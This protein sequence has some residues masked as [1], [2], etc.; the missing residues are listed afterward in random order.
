MP[1]GGCAWRHPLVCCADLHSTIADVKQRLYTFNGSNMGMVELHLKD[2]SGALL[3]RMLD[4]D[5]M[6]GYYGVQSGMTI[7]VVDNDPFS[8]SRDGGCVN[9]G[10]WPQRS[11]FEFGHEPPASASAGG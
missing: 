9:T 1:G 11:P 10:S 5:R 4:D 8:L 7:H 3:A 6:L 2:A